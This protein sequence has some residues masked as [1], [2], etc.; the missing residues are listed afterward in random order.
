MTVDNEGVVAD[1]ILISTNGV[2]L[3]KY[4]VGGRVSCILR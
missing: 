1:P 2:A 4:P 3:V